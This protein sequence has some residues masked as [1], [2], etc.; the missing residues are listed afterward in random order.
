MIEA[1]V[2]VQWHDCGSINE[3]NAQ[4]NTDIAC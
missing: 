3:N 2:V 1:Q 4:V